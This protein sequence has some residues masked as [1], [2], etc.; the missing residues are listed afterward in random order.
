AAEPETIRRGCRGVPETVS[1]RHRSGSARRASRQHARPH[2]WLGD[3]N[4]GAS[5]D[6]ERKIE[7]VYVLPESCAAAAER[8]L[9]GRAARRGDSLRVQLAK[10]QTQHDGAVDG[11]RQ[12]T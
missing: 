12:E 6:S 7:S 3:A 8:G 10:R 9:A 5:P 11:D 1:I 2:V 4:L